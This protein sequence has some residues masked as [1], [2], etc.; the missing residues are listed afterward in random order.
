MK[1][2]EL[3]PRVLFPTSALPKVY[4]D[5][6]QFDKALEYHHKALP[7]RLKA[8]GE[9]HPEVASTYVNMAGVET[10]E[11]VF[12]DRGGAPRSLAQGSCSP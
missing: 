5:Q 4:K 9:N 7:I 11:R 10:S 2:I 12:V 8:L 3:K 6:G 1:Q